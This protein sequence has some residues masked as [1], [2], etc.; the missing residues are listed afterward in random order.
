MLFEKNQG[1]SS[2]KCQFQACYPYAANFK[3]NTIKITGLM[4]EISVT[5]NEKLDILSGY[6]ARF[7]LAKTIIILISR[8]C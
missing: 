1:S 4:Q 3:K 5:K 8:G 6:Q 2:G 7:Y